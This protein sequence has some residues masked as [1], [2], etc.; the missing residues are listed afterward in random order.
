MHTAL[1]CQP[2][3]SSVWNAS[4][5]EH[6]SIFQAGAIVWSWQLPASTANSSGAVMR[7]CMNVISKKPPGLTK[8]GTVAQ[9]R[10]PQR[11]GNAI[12]KALSE[13]LSNLV[14]ACGFPPSGPRAARKSADLFRARLLSE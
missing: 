10:M 14:P 9:G 13:P 5:H 4:H 8:T 7:A 2:A 1:I 3:G 11:S 6:P 12:E